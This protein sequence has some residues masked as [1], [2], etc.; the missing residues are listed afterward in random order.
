MVTN[1]DGSAC[2]VLL[3]YAALQEPHSNERRWG[4]LFR[5][6]CGKIINTKCILEDTFELPV[7]EL[8]SCFLDPQQIH[9]SR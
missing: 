1:D 9:F 5:Y 3:V 2:S 4:L 6:D 7:E 8:H